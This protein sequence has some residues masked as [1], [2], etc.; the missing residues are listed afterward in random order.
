MPVAVRIKER[1]KA[2]HFKRLS[3]V[4]RIHVE[5]PM[6]Q[7]VRTSSVDRAYPDTSEHTHVIK[8]WRR[9]HI[10]NTYNLQIIFFTT[11]RVLL[12]KTNINL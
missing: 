1:H 2:D 4:M 3:G 12:I 7:S 11:I 5:R 9:L 8:I 6:H 10:L